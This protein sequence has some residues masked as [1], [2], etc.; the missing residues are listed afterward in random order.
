LS[1]ED[2]KRILVSHS[3]IRESRIALFAERFMRELDRAVQRAVRSAGKDPAIMEQLKQGQLAQLLGAKDLGRLAK[4][5]L[6]KTYEV[7]LRQVQEYFKLVGK[8]VDLDI[9]DIEAAEALVKLDLRKIDTVISRYIGGLESQIMREVILG[10]SIDIDDLRISLGDTAARNIDAELRTG[11][12][13]F[14]R[15]VVA[16]KAHEV[17]GE[18]PR[19]LYTGPD[20]AVTRDFCAE[21]LNPGDRD[22][23]IYTE[24]EIAAMDNGQGLD[25]LT[26]GGGWNCRHSWN[27]ISDDFE[28]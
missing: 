26:Y 7:E 5:F 28:L 21:V 18:N 27:P 3:S 14:N 6:E 19:Y 10:D 9:A 25:A 16:K 24:D 4:A 15:T 13:A 20:D 22:L 17:F 12:M 1:R 2:I 11:T 8:G 23:P